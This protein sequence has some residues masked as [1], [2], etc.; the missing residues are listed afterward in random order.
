[1][2]YH[3]ISPEVYK[4]IRNNA[5]LLDDIAV[6][7]LLD[8]DD[9]TLKLDPTNNRIGIKNSNPTKTLDVGG[10]TQVAD[11]YYT[12]DYPTIRPSLD[13]A[14]DKVKRLD[15]RV[16][17]TRTS[18]ATYVGTDGLIKTAAVDEPRFDHDPVTGESLGLLIE[19]SRTNL[20]TY[21]ENLNSGYNLV[22]VI[23]QYSASEVAPDGTT[24]T[25]TILSSNSNVGGSRY[26]YSVTQNGA[27]TYTVSCFFKN[28]STTTYFPQLRVFGIGSGQAYATFNLTGNGSI[29]DNG[30][31]VYEN[32]TITPYSNNWYRCSMTF[33]TPGNTYLGGIAVSN[34][35]TGE[36]PLFDGSNSFDDGFLVWGFQNELGSFPT[37]YIPTSGSTVTRATESVSITGTNFTDFYN[38]NE[39]TLY[40]EGRSITKGVSTSTS[41]YAL[42]SIDD[43]TNNNRFILRRCADYYQNTTNQS[44]F[45]FRYRRSSINLNLDAFPPIHDSTGN[46]PEWKDSEVHKMVFAI[47][48]D[49]SSPHDISAYGDGI[50][51]D[52]ASTGN[53]YTGNEVLTPYDAATQMRL[54]FGGASGYW[55]GHISRITYYPRRLN[56]SQLQNITL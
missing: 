53:D 49:E 7:D 12:A 14:F 47:N 5:Q 10:D 42:V 40:G 43:G 39:F 21:S 20:N 54:G 31:A 56:N 26:I 51:A 36:M 48:N 28:Q 16:T 17:F 18:T 38:P 25:V 4:N 8:L 52:F 41:N 50:S 23:K 2:A 44:G 27:G 33:T 29:T 30:G 13:L 32:S 37:S 3:G 1:M 45:T 11:L 19:E 34:S 22:G 35:S 24:G 9:G 15:S 6:A 46:L 55:N